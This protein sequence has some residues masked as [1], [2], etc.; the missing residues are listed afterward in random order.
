MLKVKAEGLDRGMRPINVEYTVQGQE[1]AD[2]TYSGTTTQTQGGGICGV[3]YAPTKISVSGER[4]TIS[5]EREGSKQCCGPVTFE[6]NKGETHLHEGV[7]P[8]SNAVKVYANP[9]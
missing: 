6:L 7:H 3:K 1:N 4:L 8:D 9:A 2:G 5:F